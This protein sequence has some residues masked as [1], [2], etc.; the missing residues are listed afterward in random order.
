MTDF[1]AFKSMVSVGIIKVIFLIG[2]ILIILVGIAVI[3]GDP[4]DNRILSF[5]GGLAIIVMGN[6]LWRVVCEAWIVIFAIHER[7]AEILEELR[8]R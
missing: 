3:L 7:L 8:K 6:L 4:L 5:L 1:L 2:A